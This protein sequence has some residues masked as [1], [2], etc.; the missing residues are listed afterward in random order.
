MT[1]PFTLPEPEDDTKPYRYNRSFKGVTVTL[2]AA[3][4]DKDALQ[5]YIKS[6]LGMKGSEDKSTEPRS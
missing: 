4:M 3:E 1:V 2:P 5:A 6:L